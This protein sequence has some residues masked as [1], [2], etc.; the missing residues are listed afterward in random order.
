MDAVQEG[1]ALVSLAARK[2]L[3]AE[4]SA[5]T[6]RQT[7][8]SGIHPGG[9][10][11]VADALVE[12]GHITA[13]QADL[14]L[15]DFA[16]AQGPKIIG[17]H[18]LVSKLGQGGM[19]A[20][21][22]AI[23]LS[24]Q[25]EVAVKVLAPHLA[26]DK[27]FV[28]RFVREA[29]AAGK[30]QHANVI[31]CYDVGVDKGTPYMSLEL[32]AGG[33]ALQRCKTA[34][35]RLGEREAVTIIRDCARGLAAIHKAGLIHRDIKPANIFLT[36]DGIAKLADLGLARST[37]GDDK[38]TQTGATVGSPAYMS[39]EQ[40]KGAHDLDIR[41]DIYSLG[42]S[43]FHLVCGEPPF[44]ASTVF[45]T[46]A[47]VINEPLP[48]PRA[49]NPALSPGCSA[50]IKKAMVKD[51]AQRLATPEALL[52]AC[53]AL[54]SGTIMTQVPAGARSDRQRAHPHHPRTPVTAPA[55]PMAL[56]VG[57]GVAA[58][59]VLIV[60][61]AA[62][63]GGSSTAPQTPAEPAPVVTASATAAPAVITPTATQPP[64]VQRP[65]ATHLRERMEERIEARRDERAGAVEPMAAP[66]VSAPMVAEPEP[67]VAAPEPPPASTLPAWADAGIATL[68]QVLAGDLV[69][70]ASTARPLPRQY[71]DAI[72]ALV[73][74][75]NELPRTWVAHKA[76]IV[77]A[78]PALP[79]LLKGVVISDVTERN[80]MF[81]D[82]RSGAEAGMPWSRL[83]AADLVMLRAIVAADEPSADDRRRFLA[84]DLTSA[85]ALAAA[86]A[87][88]PAVAA[89]QGL[90][91]IKVEV[92]AAAA[93]QAEA[94]RLAREA[95]ARRAAAMT[96]PVDERTA[97][98]LR[99]IAE[100]TQFEP[101]VIAGP[102][103]GD[104]HLRDFVVLTKSARL[105]GGR[106]IPTAGAL[107]I[108][109][110]DKVG[111]Q[112]L[113]IR[114]MPFIS[115]AGNPAHSGFYGRVED[116]NHFSN[117]VF[118][119]NTT[120]DSFGSGTFSACAFLGSRLPLPFTMNE[121]FSF[122][123]QVR[124]GQVMH[125]DFA[126][127]TVKDQATIAATD[128]CFFQSVQVQVGRPAAQ[129][130][131]ICAWDMDNSFQALLDRIEAQGH[132][133]LQLHP[134]PGRPATPFGVHA[135]TIAA[136]LDQVLVTWGSRL[137]QINR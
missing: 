10:R 132:P 45:A 18:Q 119:G 95:E 131:D 88:D 106:L 98:V 89:L 27:E 78:N 14:L 65:I 116:G 135:S 66:P 53:E 62:S 136:A 70:A 64:S 97:R 80:L 122:S 75:R 17:G 49:R 126:C 34:G 124:P 71:R 16:K 130:A 57:G 25:R 114:G 90:A 121:I 26:R 73:A 6:L 42:A 76:A 111:Y 112:P 104:V 13:A 31:G 38:M 128:K 113:V 7:I 56:Y 15:G 61:I 5:I 84:L 4:A 63:S 55:K 102:I 11:P 105:Q 29:R 129:R 79:T 137:E 23:Q 125:S 41:T 33:D 2:G 58:L 93:R 51:R 3:I 108:N 36:T 69:A 28:E 72:D 92:A 101:Q 107:V 21:F 77:A 74:A 20:V 94:E 68:D 22:K 85:E 60:I 1:V 59:V 81:R 96:G 39:P 9:A 127:V 8:E 109:L 48:D 103:S 83:T 67:V 37:S 24:M 47:K 43:L 117:A 54:L 118:F 99:H 133:R 46:V 40:A 12:Q 86:D 44:T 123:T 82:P 87:S 115:I 110:A 30:V 32:V 100:V 19:G 91:A 35:G 134:Q 120:I 50:L 52:D